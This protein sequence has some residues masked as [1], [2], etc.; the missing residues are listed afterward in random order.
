MKYSEISIKRDVSLDL[1]RLLTK[2]GKRDEVMEYYE[3]YSVYSDSVEASEL[4]ETSD[5]LL[6]VERV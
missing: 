5:M 1:A 3:K 4:K 6:Q 2:Q